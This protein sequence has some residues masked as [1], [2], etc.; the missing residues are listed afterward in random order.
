V[1]DDEKDFDPG[2][3]GKITPSWGVGLQSMKVPAEMLGGSLLVDSRAAAG[4]RVKLRVPF[5]GRL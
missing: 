2:A 4:T 3:V 1:E 5:D